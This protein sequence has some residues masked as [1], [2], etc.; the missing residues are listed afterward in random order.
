MMSYEGIEPQKRFLGL[1]VSK[2]EDSCNSRQTSHVKYVFDVPHS[3]IL[4][5][6]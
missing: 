1:T 2:G 4:T 6:S 3:T 5:F